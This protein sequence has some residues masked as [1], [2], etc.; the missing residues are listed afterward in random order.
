MT[1]ALIS[2]TVILFMFPLF[3][4]APSCR[5]E[6]VLKQAAKQFIV[7]LMLAVG[8]A[9]FSFFYASLRAWLE[10]LE[11]T[12]IIYFGSAVAAIIFLVSVILAFIYASAAV[13]RI[14]FS[15]L[16]A[17]SVVCF[18]A[19]I[20]AI[21]DARGVVLNTLENT[22]VT[23]SYRFSNG[24]VLDGAEWRVLLQTDKHIF[25]LNAGSD[26]VDVWPTSLLL[27]ASF[28]PMRREGSQ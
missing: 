21:L 22:D 7:A 5:R 2:I 3:E 26:V 11:L 9:I 12:E 17:L 18:S 16:L 1:V 13:F 20:V 4:L 27:N 28:I 8:V 19:I 14:D 24:T 23:S 10:G 15:P 25:F 6:A